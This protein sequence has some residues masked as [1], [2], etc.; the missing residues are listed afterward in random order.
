MSKKFADPSFTVSAPPPVWAPPEM[1]EIGRLPVTGAELFGRVKELGQLDDAWASERINLFSLVAWGGVGKS[2]LV[3][4]WLERMEKENYRGARRVYAWSFYSQGTGERVTSA[5]LFISDAL[6]WFGDADPTRG[7]PWDK[8]QRLARLVRQEKTLLVLDGLEPLQSHLDYERG[9]VKDP[10]LAILLSELARENPGLC[11]ITTREKIAGMERFRETALQQDLD[12]ISPEAGRALLRVGGVRGNDP[13][14]EQAV[15]DFGHHSLALKL[16]AAY[17]H[18]IP[19]HRIKAAGHIPDMEDVSEEKGRHPRRVMAAFEARFGEGPAL[20]ILRILGLFDRPIDNETLLALRREP[21]IKGLTE[22]ITE[23]TE[24]DWQN[25]LKGLRR[26][27]MVA[28]ESQHR[29]GDLDAHPLVREH[30]GQQLERTNPEAWQE[31]HRRVYAHLKGNTKRFPETLEEMGPLFSAVHHGCKAGLHEEVLHVVYWGR[32]L[33]GLQYFSTQQLGAFGAELAVVAGFF[34]PPFDRPVNG[35]S[36]ENKAFVLHAAGFHL[37]A[38]GWL[39]DAVEPMK[40]SLNIR[41]GQG[42][43]YNSAKI[44]RNLSELHLSRGD[45]SHALDLAKKCVDYAEESGDAFLRIAS[46]TVLADAMLQAGEFDQ[47]EKLFIRAEEMQKQDQP[48]YPLLDAGQGYRYCDLLLSQARFTEVLE[49]AEHTIKIVERNRWLLDI[50][51]DHLSLGRAELMQAITLGSKD[52]SR[53]ESALNQSVDSLRESGRQ[54]EVPRG[55][56]ARTELYREMQNFTAA[57]TD[58]EEALSIATNGNMRLHETDCYIGFT[59]L[60]L[61]LKQKEKA[62]ES[63]A[64][65]NAMSKEMKYGRRYKEVEALEKQL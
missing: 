47:A 33:K 23:L 3:N 59:R 4:K 53:A 55:L 36:E 9:K 42:E 54:D 62:Q 25:A 61:A 19:G 38:L 28:E 58:L 37:R 30:F 39:D 46:R 41:I 29:E 27:G 34:N 7:S 17:L 48:K 26:T 12:L 57:R 10:A 60:W 44:A 14:L 13:E 15:K 51:L 49:R 8:G 22:H 35:L 5:D 52:F 65:A 43:W 2:T 18:V 45:L 56:L 24:L 50:A 21:A 1:V 6:L 32:I 64:K 40:A 16:L 63:L 20:N 31:G 11:L